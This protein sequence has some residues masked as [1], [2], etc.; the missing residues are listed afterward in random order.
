MF[1]CTFIRSKWLLNGF[2]VRSENFCLSLLAISDPFFWATQGPF[3]GQNE[4]VLGQFGHLDLFGVILRLLY[5]HFG[6][7]L[8]SFR[9][10]LGVVFGPLD[11]F[12]DHFWAIFLTVLWPFCDWFEVYHN[13]LCENEDYCAK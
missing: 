9:L 2:S 5:D 3:W 11:R 4:V 13:F 6:I 7:I 1:L 8:V 12:W 10:H